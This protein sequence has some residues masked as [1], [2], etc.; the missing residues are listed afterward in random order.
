VHPNSIG[1]PVCESPPSPD[2]HLT[3]LSGI[4]VGLSPRG[5][6][7]GNGRTLRL[8]QD[9]QGSSGHLRSPQGSRGRR[10]QLRVALPTP[11]RRYGLHAW[12]K[13]RRRRERRGRRP[14]RPI[15]PASTH[16]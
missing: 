14:L 9:E 3:L 5:P 10:R 4:C 8:V 13:R 2:R 7:E 12:I 11:H 6:S 15:R 1:L 16:W